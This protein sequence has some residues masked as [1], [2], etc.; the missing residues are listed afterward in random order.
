MS[1]QTVGTK[2]YEDDIQ[3]LEEYEERHGVSRSEAL[4]RSV[5][6]LDSED[7]SLTVVS[8]FL[9]TGLFL[10]LSSTLWVVPYIFAQY[11]AVAVLVWL[12][13]RLRKLR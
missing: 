11:W 3:L 6:G 8:L 9:V 4:R 1:T 5:R 12:G 7:E 10:I 13:L 2:L